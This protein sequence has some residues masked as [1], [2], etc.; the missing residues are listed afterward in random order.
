[1]MSDHNN[2][3]MEREGDDFPYPK[4]STL[5]HLAESLPFL[6]ECFEFL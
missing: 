2:D 4:S 3:V 6:A 5:R 1:M